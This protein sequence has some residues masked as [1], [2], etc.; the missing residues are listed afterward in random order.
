M[1]GSPHTKK[2]IP[3]GISKKPP[4]PESELRW[5]SSLLDYKQVLICINDTQS[6]WNTINGKHIV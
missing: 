2:I 6:K 3:I 4:S 1:S 5:M